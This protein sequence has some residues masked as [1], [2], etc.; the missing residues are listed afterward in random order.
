M[1]FEHVALLWLKDYSFGERPSAHLLDSS[2]GIFGGDYEPLV[3]GSDL[4]AFHS[5]SRISGA[6]A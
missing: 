5:A 4:G 3:S 6:Q 2:V 1:H